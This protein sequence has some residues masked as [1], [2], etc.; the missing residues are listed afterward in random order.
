VENYVG[1][2]HEYYRMVTPLYREGWGDSFNFPPFAGAESLAAATAAQEC[3]IADEGGF[4][5]G[6]RVL[7]VGC[8]VGRPALTI[9]AHSGAAVTGL[10]ISPD[11][12]PI[13]RDLAAQRRLSE[14][15]RFVG[16]DAM[17]MPFQADSFDAAYVIQS[18][19]HAPDKR[20]VYREIARVV[21]PRGVFLG[22]DWLCR[23]HITRTEYAEY[24]EPICR[25]WALPHLIS[26][27]QLAELLGDAGLHV[28]ELGDVAE[29]GDM[30][31]NW[32]LFAAKGR[33]LAGRAEQTPGVRL[34][35][36]AIDAVVRAAWAGAFV[37]GYW[38]AVK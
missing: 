26:L 5:P 12:L 36:E 15:V 11:Q 3:G 18:M 9:A 1:M 35:R 19:C 31:P 17:K 29:R 8:G 16:G 33:S 4:R 2:I 28:T 24:I 38:H 27:S 23:D 22:N 21:R 30:T 14:L 10:N 13:A 6:W 7:D 25:S 20:T 34:M 32:E 37:V